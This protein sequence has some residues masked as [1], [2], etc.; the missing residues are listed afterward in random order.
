LINE[1]NELAEEHKYQDAIA[2]L[3]QS[4][5]SNR[6][7]IRTLI[8]EFTEKLPITIGV[9]I[10]PYQTE[11]IVMY[12]ET[13]PASM[14][15]AS[16]INGFRIGSNG[17]WS[18]GVSTAYF[19]LGGKYD[20]I[21][22]L[23][24]PLSQSGEGGG[25][26]TLTI[27]GDGR[28]LA[29]FEM[30]SSDPVKVFSLDISDVN[31]LRFEMTNTSNVTR[32]YGVANIV[33]STENRVTAQFNEP[34]GIYGASPTLGNEISAYRVANAR[35]L[36][37]AN[38]ASVMGT[39]YVNGMVTDGR[40]ESGGARYNINGKYTRLTGVYGPLDGIG[41]DAIGVIEFY[42]DG[43]SLGSF[44]VRAGDSVRTFTLD[45]TGVTQLRVVVV[46]TNTSWSWNT[47][48]VVADM[49]LS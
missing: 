45:V 17:N 14:M 34:I 7:E 30:D 21:S 28:M 10:T 5:F 32:L 38:P 20:F 46:H 15:G 33:L 43:R 31:Q 35:E 1:A 12:T 24:G 23:Y 8:N 40:G 48:F 47:G 22:G 16:Y 3:R 2:L 27:W 39:N 36:S 37:R 25:N 26:E 19:N 4:R 18:S 44:D 41:S 42:G 9:D 6:S 49:K 29:T 13:A 11:N